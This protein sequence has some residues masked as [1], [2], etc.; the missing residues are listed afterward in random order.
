MQDMNGKVVAV[1]SASSG[2]G[3][4][5]ARRLATHG[6]RVVLGARRTERLERLVAEM[7]AAGG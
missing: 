3:E 1:T 4:A 6:A 2:I 5:I 7:T